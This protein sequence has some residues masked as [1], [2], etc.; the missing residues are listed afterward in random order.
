MCELND[1]ELDQLF[2]H[3]E[4]GEPDSNDNCVPQVR[5]FATVRSPTEEPK[6]GARLALAEGNNGVRR[7]EG[8][9]AQGPSL[10]SIPNPRLRVSPTGPRSPVWSSF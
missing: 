5:L 7:P 3:I 4:L 10:A 1:D 6:S 8:G 2:Q 9:S